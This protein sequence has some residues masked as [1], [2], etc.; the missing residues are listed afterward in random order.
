MAVDVKTSGNGNQVITLSY[1]LIGDVWIHQFM[2]TK[3]TSMLRERGFT[4]LVL[5]D[6]HGIAW[7]YDL[8]KN[9]WFEES[10]A[11]N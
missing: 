9:D 7:K 1:V 3:A 4:K 5:T 8:V 6:G 11:K 2:K 10:K